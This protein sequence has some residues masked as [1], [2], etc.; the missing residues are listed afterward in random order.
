MVRG[1]SRD[2]SLAVLKVKVGVQKRV[3]ER[4]YNDRG[5]DRRDVRKPKLLKRK[6]RI[7][8]AQ[9]AKIP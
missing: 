7:G 9:S 8:A 3:V 6:Y 4:P 2:D 5:R 1:I